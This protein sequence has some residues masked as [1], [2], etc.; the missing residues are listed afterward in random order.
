MRISW[1][2]LL[3]SLVF[4]EPP[5]H[6]TLQQAVETALRQNPS[7]IEARHTVEEADARIRQARAIL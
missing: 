7:V 5:V 2:L 6:L 1:L 4:A 3:P